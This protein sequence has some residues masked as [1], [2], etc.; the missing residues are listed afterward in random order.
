MWKRVCFSNVTD[1]EYVEIG[2]R[3][4][5]NMCKTTQILY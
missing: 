5:R 3:Y 1:D 2:K 4:G